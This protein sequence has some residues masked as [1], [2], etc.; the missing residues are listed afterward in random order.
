VIDLSPVCLAFF[1]VQLQLHQQ[2]HQQHTTVDQP[3]GSPPDSMPLSLYG[4]MLGNVGQ[5]GL[6]QPHPTQQLPQLQSSVLHQ[7]GQLNMLGQMLLGQQLQQLSGQPGPA[8]AQLPLQI[9]QQH[10]LAAMPSQGPLQGLAA[11]AQHQLDPLALL[12]LQLQAAG[13]TVAT[14]APLHMLPAVPPQAQGGL[15]IAPAAGAGVMPQGMAGGG[16][17]A[18]GL[19][20]LV[21]AP[22]QPLVVFSMQVRP[23]C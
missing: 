2:Q 23:D 5:L 20:S 10:T 11:P 3:V 22:Q 17:T 9:L 19:A 14:T 13:V 16:G 7:Q 8:S 12:Q 21:A 4:T 15:L 1:P 18:E 6:L